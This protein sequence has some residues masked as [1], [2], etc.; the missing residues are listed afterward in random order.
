[1]TDRYQLNE[2]LSP[3][4]PSS[5]R[6]L[7]ENWELIK[8]YLRFIQRQ[9]NIMSGSEADEIISKIEATIANAEN[10]TADVAQ[11]KIE[12]E[13]ILNDLTELIANTQTA[14]NNANLAANEAS[15]LKNTLTALQGE[16][17]TL[18][19][20]LN[21]IVQAESQ[22]VTNEQSRKTDE[23]TR[24]ENEAARVLK[25][26]SR[27][28]AEQ[29]R[30]ST[31]DAQMLTAEQ[32]ITMMQYLIDNLKSYDFNLS[33]TYYFPNLIKWN[34]STF[35]ALK[36]VTGL[37]PIDD[38]INYRL[39]A[40][41]GVDG[42]GAVSSVNGIGPDVNGNVE[43]IMAL[44]NNLGSDSTT[45]GLTAA[46]GKAL[47][48]LFDG[49]QQTLS[50]HVGAT[51]NPHGVTAEQLALGNVQ[52]F[53]VATQVEAEAGTSATKYM[54]VL[55]T[56][57]AIDKN[58][59]PIQQ[60]TTALE[61]KVT[62]QLADNNQRMINVKYPPSPLV[63]A[64]GNGV[65]DDQPA[66]QA[67]IDYANLNGY[68]VYFPASIYRLNNTIKRKGRV[69]L[70]GQNMMNTV[71]RFHKS[72]GGT[73]IDTAN[74]S[75][76]G[77]TISNFKFIKDA[78]V[79]G[80][81]TGIL[82]GST[83]ANYNSAIGTFERL[84]FEGLYAG[85]RGNAETT[86]VGIFDC[87]FNDIYASSCTV[88]I[89]FDGSGNTVNHPR[90]VL[91]DVGF[92]YNY[93]NSESFAGVNVNGGIFVQNGYDITIPDLDGTR[94][95]SFNGTW[96]EQS[97]YG[98]VNI[99]KVDTKLMSFSFR[100][101][102]LSTNSV[103]FA[104]L[105][106]RNATGPISIDTCTIAQVSN[107]SIALIAPTSASGSFEVKNSLEIL[108]T[109]VRR[110]LNYT[111]DSSWKTVTLNNGWV[112]VGA[113]TVTKY[114]K[115]SDGVVHLQIGMKDGNANNAISVGQLPEG[116]RPSQSVR[117]FVYN[118]TGAK[119]V[120]MYVDGVNGSIVISGEGH[121]T[122]VWAGYVSF[123]VDA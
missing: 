120:N 95:C 37:T 33:A 57:Q 94:P 102:M 55:R 42:T 18:Q 45:A 11:A 60:S 69:S 115:T 83:L 46:Q 3:I 70:Y 97:T 114:C 10:A 16:L 99:P 96:F 77:V 50:S 17:V 75:L 117:F 26:Q 44:V 19:T 53:G 24:R 41:R 108:S 103:D 119:V 51:D 30:T 80:T 81:V 48:V 66:I 40:Q 84:Y 1:M 105:S 123:K 6:E 63:A 65:N 68:N 111:K 74:E 35:I 9:I 91:C 8:S 118:I 87:L 54:T 34:G 59:V 76:H 12:I 85:I 100:D 86:G 79:G 43:V 14:A 93:L 28:N 106:F 49:L 47:K 21:G 13:L 113:T 112:N 36:E 78:S 64:V 92:S 52:N 27:E 38:G 67:I 25:E 73:I 90:I 71:L 56:K 5:W 23:T 107:S 20:N 98:M 22:R 72:S 29:N 88:G 122:G 116:F 2:T 101:C 89:Q 4:D 7:N 104:L 82:G 58:L 15:E 39:V 62:Q 32:K 110:V 31:F 121:T 109:G 61:T